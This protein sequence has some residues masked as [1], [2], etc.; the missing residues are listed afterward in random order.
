MSLRILSIYFFES[1]RKALSP[2]EAYPMWL[3]G[4]SA[5]LWTCYNEGMPDF[6]SAPITNCPWEMM[7]LMD[8]N[9]PGD[10]PPMGLKKIG[11]ILLSRE[12]YRLAFLLVTTSYTVSFFAKASTLCN[13]LLLAWGGT[14][15]FVDL[16][17][18]RILFQSKRCIPLIVFMLLKTER[19]C[20]SRG[21]NFF[22]CFRLTGIC[23]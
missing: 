4:I 15:F 1:L 7:R 10:S 3:F 18:K 8:R 2:P 5:I 20:W 21:S 11:G 16:F 12:A 23:R 17:T 6:L 22:F 9:K 13:T 19:F 14:L